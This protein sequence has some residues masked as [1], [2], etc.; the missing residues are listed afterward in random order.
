MDRR[1][2]AQVSIDVISVGILVVLDQA[3]DYLE[4]VKRGFWCSDE[5]IKYPRQSETVPYKELVEIA[6]VAPVVFLIISEII[7]FQ[8]SKRNKLFLT[9]QE[10]WYNLITVLSTWACTFWINSVITKFIKVRVGRLRPVFLDYCNP[11]IDCDDAAWKDQYVTNFTCRV[12]HSVENFVRTSFPSGHSSESMVSMV[13]LIIYLWKRYRHNSTRY[14]VALVQI[15]VLFVGLFV[16][17]SR[18]YDNIHHWS[19]VL[20][21]IAIGTIV[22][23]VVSLAPKRLDRLQDDSDE[24]KIAA[25]SQATFRSSIA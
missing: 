25:T 24:V 17:L 22:A 16:A 14:F 12:G 21:G 2:V 1:G 10:F 13:F 15:V 20:A 6:M 3:L 5:T 23:L 7:Y 4:P 8:V 9:S 11:T 19:D 18:I